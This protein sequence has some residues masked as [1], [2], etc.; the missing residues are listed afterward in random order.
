MLPDNAGVRFSFP[1]PYLTPEQ[2]QNVR[3]WIEG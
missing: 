3:V 2:I 1:A